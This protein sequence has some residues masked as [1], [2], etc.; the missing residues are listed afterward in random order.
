MT[1]IGRILRMSAEDS[2]S[3]RTEKAS[4][5]TPPADQAAWQGMLRQL[6]G[7]H[8]G[9]GHAF[10]SLH[11]SRHKKLAGWL[12]EQI[13]LQ[14]KGHLLPLRRRA[15]EELGIE[16]DTGAPDEAANR[17]R[18]ENWEKRFAEIVAFKGKHGHL[19]VTKTNEIA[20]GLMHWRDNQRINFHAGRMH[21]ERKARL[22]AL[23]FQW[24]SPGYPH[25]STH[26]HNRISWENML[27]RL[28]AFREQHGHCEVPA[29]WQHD[30]ALGKWVGRLRQK[31]RSPQLYGAILP[32]QRAQLDKTGFAWLPE[33]INKARR[34]EERHAQLT[35][36]QQ[37]HGHVRV[38]RGN[39]TA[40]ALA[41]WLENQGILHREGRLKS[42]HKTRLESLG[43]I[44][45]PAY[46]PRKKH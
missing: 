2:S 6:A 11:D 19:R 4:E 37:Q 30:P 43:V 21:P 18:S 26:E 29:T 40:H 25:P 5:P 46:L 3:V 1:K 35:A 22:D 12:A 16:W 38:T 39:E 34:W 7:F 27:A 41:H 24:T 31:D 14:R 9:H 32:E 28:L 10:V 8:A 42:E 45:P 36:F 17:G 15:L 23:G 33:G 44:W 13:R 20:P